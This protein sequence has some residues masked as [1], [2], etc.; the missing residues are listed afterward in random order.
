MT[1]RN[2]DWLGSGILSERMRG[3]SRARAKG[4]TEAMAKRA[5]LAAWAALAAYCALSVVAGPAG[6]IA[7]RALESSNS[8]MAA[9]LEEL[10]A[11]NGGLRIELESLRSDADRAARE[12]RS[13]G[14]LRQGEAA[15]VIA[16][17]NSE[18]KELE[19]GEVLAYAPPETW[20]DSAL[21]EI[22]FGVF[23]AALAFRPPRRGSAAPGAG[24]RKRE[25][26]LF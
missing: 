18:P 13:L 22:A 17:R 26:A 6:L 15:V 16:G 7:Y 14:Y 23:L 25:A 9:N 11:D 12:A 20:P 19:V 4:G 1:S 10:R 21:K 2:A 8:R 5:A 3:P 24:G